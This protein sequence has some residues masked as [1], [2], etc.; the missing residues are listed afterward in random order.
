MTKVDGELGPFVSFVHEVAPL[1]VDPADAPERDALAVRM[2][3]TE[4]IDDSEHCALPQVKTEVARPIR[5]PDEKRYPP[6]RVC[7]FSSSQRGA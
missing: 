1:H 3:M 4:K 7:R 5:A 6:S 2:H